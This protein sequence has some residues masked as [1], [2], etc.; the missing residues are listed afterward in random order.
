MLYTKIE[1]RQSL[2]DCLVDFILVMLFLL[3]SSLNLLLSVLAQNV[4]IN[5]DMSMMIIIFMAFLTKLKKLVPFDYKKYVVIIKQDQHQR[6][7][8]L[9][10]YLLIL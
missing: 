1:E 8:F 5:S 4:V 6:I 3:L 2:L 10:F 9:L 7:K